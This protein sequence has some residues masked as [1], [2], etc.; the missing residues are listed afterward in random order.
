MRA[1]GT[2]FPDPFWPEIAGWGSS[3]ATW[4]FSHAM[5]MR[6]LYSFDIACG[7]YSLQCT[8][9]R[10]MCAYNPN[11]YNAQTAQHIMWEREKGPNGP[12]QS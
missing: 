4:L 8:C 7:M 1:R 10:S 6:W 9:I 3:D 5:T 12:D 11:L 2:L